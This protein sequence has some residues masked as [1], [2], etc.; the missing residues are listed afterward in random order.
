MAGDDPADGLA[1]DHPI[2]RVHPRSQADD[3]QD[4]GSLVGKD[5]KARCP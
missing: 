5:M 3:L 1:N 4:E 2:L